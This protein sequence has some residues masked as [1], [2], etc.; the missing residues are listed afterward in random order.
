MATVELTHDAW[1]DYRALPRIVRERVQKVLHRL[2]KWPHVS[3]VKALSGNLTGSF[4]IR[5]GAYRIRFRVRGEL[6]LVDKI[7]HRK[8]IYEN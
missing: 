4:R 3:G 1:N 2:E 5:T 6:V 8:D 7:G